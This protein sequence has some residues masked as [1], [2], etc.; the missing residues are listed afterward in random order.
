VEFFLS[1][2]VIE[3]LNDDRT[4]CART[5]LLAIREQGPSEWPEI[6]FL[7]V[8]YPTTY[9]RIVWSGHVMDTVR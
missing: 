5:Q 8:L 6:T 9:G 2:N 1:R 3:E 4:L 7:I